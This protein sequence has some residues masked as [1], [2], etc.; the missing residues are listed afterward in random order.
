MVTHSAGI[1]NIIATSAT[2]M[3]FFIELVS[4]L[5]ATNCLFERSYEK[6]NITLVVIIVIKLVAFQTHIVIV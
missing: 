2:T 4:T 5:K 1:S 3:Y 6:Q